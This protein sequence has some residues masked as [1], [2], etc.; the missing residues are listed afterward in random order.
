MKYKEEILNEDAVDE[1]SADVQTYLNGLGAESRNI[2]RIRL[3]AEEVL[4]NI[5]EHYGKDKRISVGIGKQFGRH[6]FRLRYEG[7]PFN[8]VN[9]SENPLSDYLIRSLELAPEWNCKGKLNTVSILLSDKQK[10][11]MMFYIILAVSAAVIAGLAGN[12]LPKDIRLAI[13]ESVLSP[14]SNCFL[15]LLGTFAG[16]MIC[17]TICSGMLGMGDTE[18]LGKTGKSVIAR[19]IVISAAI[20]LA[21][22]L[23]TIPFVDLDFSS[24]GK[25]QASVFDQISQMFFDMFPTN[26][27]DPFKTGNTFQIIIIAVI[28]GCGLLAMGERGNNIKD[29][30]T[31]SAFMLQQIVSS[32]CTMV[33]LFVFCMLL[34]MIWSGRTRTLLTAIKPLILVATMMVIISVVI[35]LISSARLKCP[36]KQLINKILPAFLVAF[37]SASSLSAFQIGMETCERKLGVNKH[38]ASFVYPLGSV[39]YK[40]ASVAYFTILV[41]TFAETYQIAVNVPWLVMTVVIATMIAIA[42]AP[43][44]G[45]D[46]LCYTILFS[47]LGIPSE[48]IILATACGVILDYIVTGVNVT[49]LIFQIACD[50]KRLNNLEQTEK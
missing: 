35:L 6:M 12:A 33:P 40:P 3:T 14:I 44:P 8:P 13:G 26:I 38:F 48:A 23:V 10:R 50:A 16:I 2:Q 30:V 47:G 27:I 29:L 7:D 42:M 22:V 20:S 11:S 45:A 18:S 5:I 17:L 46:I 36:P 43:I 39:I 25:G 1:I 19:F 15:G 32:V 24:R 37:T 34:E 28:I 49:L 9:D 41:C 31:D 21:S 4:L